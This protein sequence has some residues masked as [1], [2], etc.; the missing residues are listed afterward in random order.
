MRDQ[1]LSHLGELCE[2]GRGA[3]VATEPARSVQDHR[4]AAK[5]REA[6]QELVFGRTQWR[7]LEQRFESHEIPG[8]QRDADGGFDFVGQLDRVHDSVEELGVADVDLVALHPARLQA[9]GRER[10]PLGIGHGARRSDELG[11]HLVGLAAL[12]EPALARREHGTGVAE[13]YRQRRSPELAGDE[14]SHGHG[15]LADQPDDLAARIGEL[16]EAASLLGADATLEHL[17][18]LDHRRDHVAGTPTAHF[19]EVGFLRLPQ[20]LSLRPPTVAVPWGPA[21]A[22]YCQL[23]V[24]PRD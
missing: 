2:R 19:G 4:A 5:S 13:P 20:H 11:A 17:G 8:C 14:P 24:T 6:Q 23:T 21:H 12:V 10:D 15:A 1:E 16:E 3:T 9:P 7:L 18:A 22:Y